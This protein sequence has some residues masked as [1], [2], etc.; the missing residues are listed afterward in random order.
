MLNKVSYLRVS[1]DRRDVVGQVAASRLNLPGRRRS[2]FSFD[3]ESFSV[4]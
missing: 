4:E 1:V 3:A 2:F